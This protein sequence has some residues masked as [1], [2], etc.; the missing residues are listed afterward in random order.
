MKRGLPPL[1]TPPEPALM[2][3]QIRALAPEE[4]PLQ[5]AENVAVVSTVALAVR[6]TVPKLTLVMVKVQLSAAHA[7]SGKATSTASARIG[8]MRTTGCGKNSLAG[9]RADH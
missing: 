1:P 2:F 5:V 3:G 8:A 6:S 4:P 9:Q 7:G